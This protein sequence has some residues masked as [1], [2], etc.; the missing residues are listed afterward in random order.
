M[1]QGS[2]C[3][4]CQGG[5]RAGLP[6]PQRPG[7]RRESGLIAEGKGGR[8][9]EPAALGSS[10]VNLQLIRKWGYTDGEVKIKPLPPEPLLQ[11]HLLFLHQLPPHHLLSPLCSQMM[12]YFQDRVR[13]E[14]KHQ[15]VK[16]VNNTPRRQERLGMMSLPLQFKVS[17]HLSTLSCDQ[18]CKRPNFEFNKHNAKPWA[19]GS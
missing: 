7:P 11:T 9:A 8:H 19:S 2:R 5:L 4:L 10:E 6:G 15:T 14:K 17:A 12:A 3:W 18:I 13:N 1:G 16:K